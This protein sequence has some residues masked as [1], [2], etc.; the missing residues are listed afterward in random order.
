MKEIELQEIKEIKEIVKNQLKEFKDN[1]W[2]W[3]NGKKAD[4]R[5]E[6][7]RKMENARDL[8]KMWLERN[9]VVYK[10]ASGG[11]RPE[12]FLRND[13]FLSTFSGILFETEINNI[14]VKIEE[15]IDHSASN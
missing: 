8:I 3:E 5:K 11:E 1:K 14:L 7:K 13:F 4:I 6:G 2:D 9:P 12:G 15:L 10:I